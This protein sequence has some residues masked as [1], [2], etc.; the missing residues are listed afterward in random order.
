VPAY[1]VEVAT[2]SHDDLRAGQTET[3]LSVVSV[4]AD[5]DPEAMLIACQMAACTS[6]AMPTQATLLDFP[7]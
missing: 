2:A 5:S 4:T 6:G 7:T 1:R 3:R